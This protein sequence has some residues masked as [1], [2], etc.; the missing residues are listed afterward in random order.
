M[1]PLPG[2][3]GSSHLAPD[4]DS[5]RSGK[6]PAKPGAAVGAGWAARLLTGRVARRRAIPALAPLAWH[7]TVPPPG[8]VLARP[9]PPRGA[10]GLGLGLGI[11]PSLATPA[12]QSCRAGNGAA[13]SRN[14]AQGAG[15]GDASCRCHLAPPPRG[16]LPQV[17]EAGALV[18]VVSWA[19]WGPSA[20][21]YTRE[22]EACAGRSLQGCAFRAKLL[23]I[24]AALHCNLR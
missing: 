17:P 7:P 4:A 21:I 14:L 19:G 1:L 10:E 8:G 23:I 13:L 12:F 18:H 16:E 15:Q 22:E 9:D 24:R 5:S 20:L 2:H 3:W 6:Q 11:K